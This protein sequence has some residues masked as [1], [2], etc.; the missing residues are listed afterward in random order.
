MRSL[1]PS[2]TRGDIPHP[3]PLPH[4]GG[5]GRAADYGR[6]WAMRWSRGPSPTRGA[7]PHKGGPPPQGGRATDTA[8]GGGQR[9]RRRGE[10]DGD[11]DG[12]RAADTDTGG[13][14]RR[15]RRGDMSLHGIRRDV[16]VQ[17]LYMIACLHD[18]V[19]WIAVIAR[20]HSALYQPSLSTRD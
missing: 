8:T 16:A 1:A 14:R 6:R 18:C 15:R 5:G 3:Q 4:E 11:G 17:R 7:L 20:T 2:P 9:R 13:G 10:G 12:G 19:V